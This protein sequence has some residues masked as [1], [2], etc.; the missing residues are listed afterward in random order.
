MPRIGISGFFMQ[1]GS[2][3]SGRVDVSETGS[4][5]HGIHL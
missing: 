1:V 5:V 2:G 4:T 3:Q